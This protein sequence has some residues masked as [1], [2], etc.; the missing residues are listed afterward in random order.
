MKAKIMILI[1][2]SIITLIHC[3]KKEIIPSKVIA[4][5]ENK[6]A[7]V[8]FTLIKRLEISDIQSPKIALQEG[9]NVYVYGNS[10]QKGKKNFLVNIYNRELEFVSQ[11]QFQLGQGPGDVGLTNIISPF[12]DNIY[13]C[14]NSNLRVSIYDGDFKYIKFI[15]YGNSRFYPFELINEGRHFIT[16]TTV[17]ERNLEAISFLLGSFPTMKAKEYY[18]TEFYSI[19]DSKHRVLLGENTEHSFFFK[20]DFIYLLIPQ[21]YHILKFDLKGKKV[22]ELI[23]KVKAIETDEDLTAQFLEEQGYKGNKYKFRFS[24]VVTQTS[25][26]VPLRNGFVVP[27]RKNYSI[28]CQDSTEGDYF[29]YQLEFKGKVALPCFYNMFKIALG[30]PIISTKNDSTYLYLLNEVEENFILEKWE[31]SE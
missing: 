6:A 16:W 27:R 10:L 23:A 2:I 24:N 15:S 30:N 22:G 14:E 8:T 12:K 25:F 9:G 18:R 26:M 29:S 28:K 20:M 5:D 11:K 13:I 21:K 4:I 19:Y 17:D 7:K 3:E 1:S 31:V